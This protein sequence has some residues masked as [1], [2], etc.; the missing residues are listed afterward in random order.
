M[1]AVVAVLAGCA[2]PPIRAVTEA[3]SSGQRSEIVVVRSGWHVD[4]GFH[5]SEL[6][7]PLDAVSRLQPGESYVLFGFGDRRYLLTQDQS[8]CSGLL[9]LW[10]GPGLILV[11]GL[12]APPEPAFSQDQTIRIKVT[13]AQARAAEAFIRASMSQ[14]EKAVEPVATGPYD[15]TVYYASNPI[16]RGFT[17]ATPGRRKSL[18]PPACRFSVAVSFS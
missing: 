12:A 3:D 18:R 13:N 11:S 4:V 8:S 1:R 5:A 9:A 17:L 6:H 7:A 16:Y 15:G 2:G 14:G 10:P